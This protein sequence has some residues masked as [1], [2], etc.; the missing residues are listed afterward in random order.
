VSRPPQLDQA[1]TD[2]LQDALAA[3]HAALWSYSLAVAFLTDDQ[4]DRAR[5]DAAEHL[6]LRSAVERTLTRFG[7][8]AVSAEPAY[9]I[10]EPVVDAGS[11]ARLVAVAESDALAAWR[12]VLERCPDPGVRKPALQA[13]TDGT[14]RSAR[15]R[16]VVGSPP[17]VPVFPGRPDR[18]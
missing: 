3:E 5:S 8:P 17:A 9:A 2:A 7:V 4:R 10:P 6:E 15:W 1:S 13:L 16:V 14:L 12:S 18:T 11:A